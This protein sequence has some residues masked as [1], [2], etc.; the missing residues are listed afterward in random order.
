MNAIKPKKLRL[1]YNNIPN[2]SLQNWKLMKKIS[3]GY[4]ESVAME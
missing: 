2:M 3:E 4:Q 1:D